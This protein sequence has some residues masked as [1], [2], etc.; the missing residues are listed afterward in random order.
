MAEPRSIQSANIAERLLGNL[1]TRLPEEIRLPLI[2]VI[3]TAYNAERYVRATLES[4]AAQQYEHFECILVDDGSKDGTLAVI[5]AFLA[6]RQDP[7][8]TL[9]RHEGNKGQLSGQITGLRAS[10]GTFVTYVDADDILLPDCLELH[11]AVHLGCEPIVAMTC[12]D[13]ATID[14]N[15]V[16]L[17]GH[18]R[19]I[20]PLLWSWLYPSPLE[21]TVDIFGQ[22][23]ICRIVPPSAANAIVLSDQY[24]WTTQSF[25]MYRRD[26]LE[27]ILPDETALFR[28]C[29]DYYLS[30]MTHAFNTTILVSRAGGAYRLHSANSFT[31]RPLTS[32]DQNSGDSVLFAWQ[33]VELGKLAS[34]VI[35]E[36][37]ERFAALYGEYDVARAL[38]GLPRRYRPAV[39][40]L[41][42]RRLGTRASMKVYIVAQISQR[43]A[44][45]RAS[46]HTAARTIWAGL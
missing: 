45:L 4:I 2:S 31:H 7:R 17:A 27:L 9:V 43:V 39:F 34:K 36:R 28:V 22:S 16:L 21:T 41:I 5:E 23:N 6:E 15:N 11:L 3:V 8:F 19:E 33:A 44:K 30:R 1:A 13:S 46:C 24:Y 35:M 25:M 29:A 10:S 40:G 26:F 18:H 42:R 38:L 20:H 12:L 37:F 14:E 32:A